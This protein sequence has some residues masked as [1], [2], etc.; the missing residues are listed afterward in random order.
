MKQ[1]FRM[2]PVKAIEPSPDNPR[3]FDGKDPG[4]K[5][6]VE[7]IDAQGVIVPIHV[8]THP[9][10]GGGF[11]LLAGERRWRACLHLGR[12]EIPA[13]DHGTI[14]DAEAFEITFTEN[15]RRQDLKPLEAGKAVSILLGKH[16]D[17]VAAVAA[18]MGQTPHWVQTHAQIDRGLSGD[19]KAAAVTN[20]RFIP[21][22][23]GHWVEVARLAPSVQKKLLK[24][25]EGGDAWSA[26]R[27]SVDGLKDHIKLDRRLL[28][29]APFET[30]ECLE[31][32]Q[33]RTGHCPLLWAGDVEKVSGQ[34]DACLDPACWDRKAVKAIRVTFAAKTAEKGQGDALALD[35]KKYTWPDTPDKVM[36]QAFGKKRVHIDDVTVCK[37]GDEGAVPAIVVAGCGKGALKW[38]QREKV[39]ASSG[40]AVKDA[41]AAQ[42]QADHQKASARWEGIE[43]ELLQQVVAAP[44]PALPILALLSQFLEGALDW[45]KRGE[46]LGEALAR[47]QSPAFEV[48]LSQEIWDDI[49]ACFTDNGY[50]S[51]ERDELQ[52]LADLVGVNFNVQGRYDELEAEDKAVEPDL[53]IACV[54]PK[55]TTA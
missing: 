12:D 22:T 7:S 3:T 9:M 55:T 50:Y 43:S 27:W 30:T 52:G 28:K 14:S 2:I 25:C 53:C 4:F 46:R 45:N 17:D 6:L 49:K 34:K 29:H 48:W 18:R 15:F 11:E 1:Q 35:V 8:R 26:N 40:T 39:D 24:H 16:A 23:A 32:C 36:K 38:I 44:R 21:W 42:R 37:E 13:I 10:K 47:Y 33:K 31:S 51:F 19:W 41:R 5:A 54:K 20:E